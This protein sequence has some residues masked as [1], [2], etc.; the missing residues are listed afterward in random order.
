[1]AFWT[2]VADVHNNR[3]LK[4]RY[5]RTQATPQAVMLSPE[6]ELAVWPGAV[7]Y[8][9]SK[10]EARVCTGDQVPAGLC[11]TW[12]KEMELTGA[13]DIAMWVMG[14]DAIMALTAYKGDEFDTEADWA[15][16]VAKLDNGEAVYLKAND[17]GQLTVGGDKDTGACRLIGMEGA[18]TLLIAGI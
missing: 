6:E 2:N 4:P 13:E 1:M 15:S 10:G 8:T 18:N 9:D 3:P 5:T 12:T 14:N 16:E 17:K 11:G 7:V